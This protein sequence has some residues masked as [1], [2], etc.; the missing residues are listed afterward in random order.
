MKKM[1]SHYPGHK[2]SEKDEDMMMSEE[3]IVEI[4]IQL[5]Q[6]PFRPKKPNLSIMQLFVFRKIF[7]SF[8]SIFF[9]TIIYGY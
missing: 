9:E 4:Q 7:I 5:W 3:V 1:G 2:T 6:T 8:G